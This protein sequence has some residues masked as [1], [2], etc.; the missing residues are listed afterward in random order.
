MNIKA[1]LINELYKTFDISLAAGTP[2]MLETELALYINDLIEKDFQRL[3]SIL[4]RVDVDEDKL[5][6]F[7][8]EEN[9]KDAA[10]IIARLIIERQSQKIRTRNEYK[11]IPKD[12]FQ[13]PA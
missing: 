3:V 12:N 7:L 11:D 6:R 8:K 13:N 9:G 10:L 2:D 1:D 4:Y 5:K